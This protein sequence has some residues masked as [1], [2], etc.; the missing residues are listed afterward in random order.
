MRLG[1]SVSFA[2]ILG[3]AAALTPLVGT[4]ATRLDGPVLAAAHLADSTDDGPHV[5]W[6]N[7]SSAI[8]F[9]WCNGG[10]EAQRFRVSRTLRFDGLC[11]DSVVAYAI[12][13]ETP[14]VQP[15]RFANVPKILTVSDIHGEYEAFVSIL[16][17]AGVISNTLHWIWGKGHLV[18]LGDVFDRGSG[19]TESL[20]LIHRLETEAADAGGRVH[21]VLGNHELMVLRGDLRYVNAKYLDGIVRAT[22]ITYDDLYGPD[23]ELGR[24]LRSKHTAIRLNGILFVHGGIGPA[25]VERGMRLEALNDAVRASL[26]LRSYALVFSDT[27]QLL[28]G[29]EGPFWYRGYHYALGSYPRASPED[30]ETVLDFYDADAVVVG[31]TEIEQ[32]L[33]LYDGRVIGVDVPVEDLGGFQALLWEG[34]SF[35]RVT[36]AGAI[37]PLET[38]P[39]GAP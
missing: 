11:G 34:G 33:S 19:V 12:S 39:A 16:Q 5:Y 27:A 15:S 37:E 36:P 31:H 1:L 23:M 24:W 18:V 2:V 14:R 29:S 25:V 13:N 21:F 28:L 3:T 10:L 22:R 35:S 17:N 8:V 38:V 7:R 20:W 6:V 9:H 4:T 30:V 32:V 26:D